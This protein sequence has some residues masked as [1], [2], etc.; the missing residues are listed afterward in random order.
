[1]LLDEIDRRDVCVEIDREVVGVVD[2][3]EAR[4]QQRAS[5][6]SGHHLLNEP[7][8]E[9]A[10]EL[11]RARHSP[12]P[13]RCWRGDNSAMSGLKNSATVQLVTMRSFRERSG[14]WYRW[15]VL[16]THQAGKP[17]SRT[18]PGSSAMPLYRPSVAT[19]PSMRKW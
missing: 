19:W 8:V 6:R 16:V 13:C 1:D 14:T 10:D 18:W 2:A 11:D 3:R 5:V 12:R 9:V 4:R 17:R 15:Y 7:L